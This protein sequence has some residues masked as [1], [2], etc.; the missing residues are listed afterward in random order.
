M[1]YYIVQPG[2]TLDKISKNF[3]VTREALMKANHFTDE[4]VVPE[5]VLVIP[6]G[7]QE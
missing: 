6:V 1:L 3:G 4:I 2:D 5:L 7:N